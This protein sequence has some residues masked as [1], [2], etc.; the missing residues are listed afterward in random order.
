MWGTGMEFV[1]S[2]TGPIVRQSTEAVPN[3]TEGFVR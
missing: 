2:E 3:L 1:P